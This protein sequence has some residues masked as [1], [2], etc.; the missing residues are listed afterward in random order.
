M[1]VKLMHLKIM[2]YALYVKQQ[3]QI[4]IPV[5]IH[6]YVQDVKMDLLCRRILKDALI[7]QLKSM[8]VKIV[9]QKLT[10]QFVKMIL[11]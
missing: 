1:L 2:E 3:Y 8:D 5:K 11:L 7:V 9:L 10:V 6:I 4:V